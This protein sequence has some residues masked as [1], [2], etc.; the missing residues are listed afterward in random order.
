MWS[1]NARDVGGLPTRYGVPTRAGALVRTDAFDAVSD[2]LRALDAGLV[3]DLRSDWELKEPHPLDG[4]PAYRRIPWIDPEAE[5]LRDPEAEP[6]LL[7][8][9]RNSLTRNAKHIREIFAAIA[10][11]PADRPVVIHCKAGKD[12]T[13]LTIAILLELAG[14]PRSR[15]AAD[16]AIS[17]VHLGLQDGPEFSR[18]RPETILGSLDHLD[19]LG[20]V[21]GYLSWLGLTRS[22]LHRL[23]TRLV[24]V[25]VEAIVFD[26]DGLLMDTETTM[27]ESWQAEWA[28]HGLELDLENFWPGHGGNVT[29]DRY[30]VLA[31]AV[32]AGFDRTASHARRIAHRDRLHADLDFRPGI[33]DWI[34][35]AREFGLKVGIASSSDRSWVVGHLDRVGAVGLFD[36]I[37]TGDDVATHKPDP[38]IYELALR[39]LDVQF[40]VAVEDTPHGVAAAQAEGLYAV[41]VPNPYVAL[42]AVANADLVLSSADDLSLTELLLSARPGG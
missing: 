21:R 19:S 34:R 36:Q 2:E 33:R 12:R 6:R 26:F 32:G 38:A 35:S 28:H 37:V 17:E 7:D 39:R 40:A 27:V 1:P 30:D 29:E 3:L 4:L 9:Y 31:A 20:G 11:A 8:V 25:E 18:T 10:D 24:P 15:I 5:R 16:Y 22:Q 13:G 14:V 41:A 42:G 23:A